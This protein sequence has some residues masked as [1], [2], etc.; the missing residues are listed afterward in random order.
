M[1]DADVMVDLLTVSP[2][3]L[4]TMLCQ[5]MQRN[6]ERGMAKSFGDIFDGS[7]ACV[8]IVKKPTAISLNDSVSKLRGFKQPPPLDARGRMLIQVAAVG[9]I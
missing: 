6:H 8:D 4:D 3:L 1:S 2:A 5:A 7:R 9:G